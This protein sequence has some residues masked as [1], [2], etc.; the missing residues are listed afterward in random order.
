MNIQGITA[1]ITGASRGIG[2]AIALELAR[3][4]VG[5]L[6][7]VARDRQ[8]LAE[9]AAE[10]S[11][12]EVE[13]ITLALD[14]TQPTEVNI[15]LAQAWRTHGPID[16][17]VN[18]AGVAHQTPFLKSKLPQVQ[19]E[20]SLNLM[21]LYTVTRAIARRMATRNQ[22]TIVNVSSLMGK[23]AAPTMSTYSA[24]KF[25]I[26]GFTE[27]LRSELAQHNIKVMALLPTL[28]DTDMTR[29]LQLFRWVTPMTPQQVAQVLII[30]LR[31]DSPEILVGWQSHLAVWCRRIAPSV[32]NK[33]L[34]MA[35]PLSRNYPESPT[36]WRRVGAASR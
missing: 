34:K 28:T 36:A 22:G 27:A 26:L 29:R 16:L 15:A 7:L 23:I 4:G 20:L 8:K 17:L 1:L 10:L 2:R 12:M 31:K 5:R 19:E 9:L 14:L 24:T 30:G 32:M 21:G 18:C 33:V 25:A 13:V 6:L 35:S 3:N 11:D